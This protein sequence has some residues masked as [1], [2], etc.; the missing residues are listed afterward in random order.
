MPVARQRL[1]FDD[2][3]RDDGVTLGGTGAETGDR[4]PKIGSSVTIG[5]NATLLGNIYIGDNS[6]IGAS[7]VV[8]KDVKANSRVVGNPARYL[9]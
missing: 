6:L 5:A 9:S 4:H 3:P 7:T 8:L 2:T 1:V